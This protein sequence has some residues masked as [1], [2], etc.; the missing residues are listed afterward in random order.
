[1]DTTDTLPTPTFAAET[2]ASACAGAELLTAMIRTSIFDDGALPPAEMFEWYALDV[3][4]RAT[5][6]RHNRSHGADNR[7]LLMETEMELKAIQM[8]LDKT[9]QFGLSA[10]VQD[11]VRVAELKYGRM[12]VT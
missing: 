7:E 5:I 1:M 9:K 4:Y 3:A 2:A 12:L 8:I 6:A 10:K 11:I